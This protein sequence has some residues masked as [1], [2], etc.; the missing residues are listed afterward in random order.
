MFWDG[1]GHWWEVRQGPD[2][3]RNLCVHPLGAAS[4]ARSRPP[5]LPILGKAQGQGPVRHDPGICMPL[6]HRGVSQSH[7]GWTHVAGLLTS[8]AASM[9]S[10]LWGPCLP[11]CPVEPHRLRALVPHW[12]LPS[13]HRWIFAGVNYGVM[14]SCIRGLC[15]CPQSEVHWES[16]S[17]G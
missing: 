8:S 11:W 4:M 16:H 1:G 14:S 7:G 13:C 6:A 17:H 2:N 9:L 12:S 5:C 3:P 15:P 10:F